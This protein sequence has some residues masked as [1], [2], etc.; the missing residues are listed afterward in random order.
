MAVMGC[1][2]L[3]VPECSLLAGRADGEYMFLAV[4]VSECSCLAGPVDGVL[5]LFFL[6]FA[7]AWLGVLFAS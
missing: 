1:D 2:W 6:I 7:L 3:C 4:H 5:L